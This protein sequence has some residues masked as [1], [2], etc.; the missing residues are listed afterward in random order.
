[1]FEQERTVRYSELAHTGCVELPQIIHYFQDAST[2][3]SETLGRGIEYMATHHRAWLL[4]AWGVEVDRN[5]GLGEILRVQTWPYDF[6]GFFAYRNFQIIDEQGVSIA[7]AYSIWFHMDTDKGVPMRIT[8]EAV[9]PYAYAEKLDM[10]YGKRKLILP[11]PEETL[12]PITILKSFIDT[13]GHVNN[14]KYIEM[15][16]EAIP[17]DFVIEQMRAEYKKAAMYGDVV[18]PHLTRTDNCVTVQLCN[19]Q[20]ELFAAVV[21]KGRK[22]ND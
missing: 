18:Y 14:E 19:E 9:A 11:E 2:E 5:P 13:N 20:G 12:P 22:K 17:D 15:A 7:R 21:L 8:E 1:M 10:E 6:K 4:S 16:M 3:Q